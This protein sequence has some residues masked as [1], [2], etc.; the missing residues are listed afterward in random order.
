[1]TTRAQLP[2]AVLLATL[3]ACTTPEP[4][5]PAPPAPAPASV[6]VAVAAPAS[7]PPPA[8]PPLVAMPFDD[9]VA[10]SGKKLFED[11]AALVGTQ[12]RSLIVD[13]LVDASTGQ[14][15]LASAEMGRALVGTVK[16]SH[17][18]WRVRDFNRST[19]AETPLLVIGTLTA[20]N[21]K[22]NTPDPADA[23]RICLRVIDLKTGRV[24]AKGLSRATTETVNAAPLPV[25]RDAPTW[26]KDNTVN[27]YIK[28]C[29]GTPNIG[30]PIDTTYLLR[31]PA[32]AVINEAQQAYGDNR[33]ADALRLFREASVVAEPDDLRVLN[34]L[35]ATSWRLGKKREAGEAFHKIAVRGV[36]TRQLPL[37]MFFGTGSATLLPEMQPQYTLWLHE[38]A[39][40]SSAAS[41][42]LRV[43]GHTS[44]TGSAIRNEALS[45]Q[46]AAY[47][48]ER[49]EASEGKLRGKVSSEG[50]GSRENLIGLG[51]D[52]ARDTLDRRVEFRVV[53]CAT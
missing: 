27:G 1:M 12:E 8:P 20:I 35:Y 26:S 38:V 41:A 22:P 44:K 30:D 36:A 3:V 24:V 14:Q 53:S 29:Q 40:A 43:V 11:A 19:L 31:L 5:K 47:V 48:R 28:S 23:Y 49:L 45:T 10:R 46:R 42:C 37:K 18:Y 17:P 33:I 6:P 34:G 52:D 25:F 16:A 32:A 4:P 9:A 50:V 13:P 2:L 15:T 51:T 21:T 39:L 7:T